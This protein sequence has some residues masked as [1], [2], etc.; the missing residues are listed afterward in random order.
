MEEKEKSFDLIYEIK[1]IFDVWFEPQ[2]MFQKVLLHKK[3][4]IPLII[5]F[6]FAIPQTISTAKILHQDGIKYIQMNQRMN[7][8]AKKLALD[9][10]KDFNSQKL[11]IRQ[12]IS[13]AVVMPISLFLVSGIILL[14]A[15]LFGGNL[16]YI[17]VL[18]IVS[19]SSYIDWLW[20]SAIKTILTLIKGTSI[21]VS[22]GLSLFFASEPFSKTYR[23][24]SS[25]D[26]FNIWSY[27]LI[28]IGLSIVM[29][30]NL[31]KCLIIVF[32]A[33]I[34]KVSLMIIPQLFF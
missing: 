11:V 24:L 25:F 20:G 28:A 17:S 4:W 31:K 1:A 26:F 9:K 13:S 23:I 6:I 7:D 14:V 19:Y 3:F 33:Y 12:L 30:A 27:V 16:T 15:T 21:G 32:V 10:M 8:E 2:K 34:F 22:T 18:T 5:I 29:K